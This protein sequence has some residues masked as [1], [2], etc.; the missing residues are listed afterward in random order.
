MNKPSMLF[1]LAVTCPLLTSA[2]MLTIPAPI[3]V[4]GTDVFSGPTFVVAG[5][6][7]ASDTLNVTASGTVDLASGLFTANAAGVIVA[8][9]TTN[10]GHHP[11]E[12]APGPGGRPFAA[13]LIGNASLGFFP[14]FAPN[15][16][17]GLGDPTP[18][19]VLEANRTLADIF[20][21]SVAIPSG[22][23]LQFRINDSNTGDNSGAFRLTSA[24]AGVVI[25]EPSTILLTAAGLMAAMA[26]RKRFST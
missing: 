1:L 14:V 20:G 4:A 16:A 11:G 17:T 23:T 13:L 18:P 21:A 3:T 10:T 26:G 8:P 12:T 22:T 2:A 9:A 25:P 7:A 5:S 24:G 15:A 6:F 19:T